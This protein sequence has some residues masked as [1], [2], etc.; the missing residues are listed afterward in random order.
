MIPQYVRHKVYDRHPFVVELSTGLLHIPLVNYHCKLVG[1]ALADISDIDLLLQYSWSKLTREFS[2]T[3]YAISNVRILMHEVITGH[4]APPGY[5]INHIN[6]CGLDNRRKNIN[7]ITKS[8]N[9]QNK[10][11]KVESMSEYKGVFPRDNKWAANI[12]VNSINYYLGRF[13]NEIDAARIYDIHALFHHRETAYTNGRLTEYEKNWVLS[14]GIP[15][16]YEAKR[17]KIRV[18]PECISQV[19]NTNK[20][21]LMITRD[22]ES[23]RKTV[24]SLDEAI[25][26]KEEFIAS[27]DKRRDQIETDRL[28]KPTL[29][30]LGEYIIICVTKKG[31]R[32]EFIVD[33]EVWRVVSKFTWNLTKK[34]YC[35]G[36]TDLGRMTLHQYIYIKFA[37]SIPEDLSID[38]VITMRKDDNRLSNLR[39]A[40][41]SLQ[42]HNRIKAKDSFE[43]YR[44]VSFRDGSY[45]VVIN[46]TPRGSFKTE[47]EA[48]TR[49]NEVF[50]EI[51]AGNAY[52]NVIDHSK[53]TTAENRIPAELVTAEFIRNL[54]YI[55]D[56]RNI[57]KLRGLNAGSKGSIPLRKI[58]GDTFEATKEAVIAALFPQNKLTIQ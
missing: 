44:G 58:T 40:T 1:W 51:Y 36:L 8:S 31:T 19:Q 37:G 33:E 6:R 42:S 57:I 11:K 4:K 22:G 45:H 30:H 14:Y 47:E 43:K 48:A 5:D 15:P 23:F 13:K 34:V 2:L 17:R 39:L 3:S 56:L 7:V 49:A 20:Y 53:T 28:S 50:T 29:N 21:L 41:K 35:K 26:L 55:K 12:T 25:Q 24:H 10:D 54:K 18:L 38:H 9:A 16:G 52:L 27:C 46:S 32:H